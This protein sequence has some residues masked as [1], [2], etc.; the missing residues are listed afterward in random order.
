RQSQVEHH[1]VGMLF[2]DVFQRGES[3]AGHDHLEARERE[4]RFVHRGKSRVIFDNQNAT[5]RHPHTSKGTST[6]SIPT[7]RATGYGLW[8]TG[9]GLP[10]TGYVRGVKLAP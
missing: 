1:E 2:V 7:Q 5:L 9:Y 4:R 6:T 8:A 3:V 10:A